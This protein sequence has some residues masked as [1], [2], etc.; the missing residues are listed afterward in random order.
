VNAGTPA[1]TNAAWSE[2]RHLTNPL[3][4]RYSAITWNAHRIHY[5]ADYAREEEGYPAIVQ[6]GGLTMQLLLDAAVRNAPGATLAHF[7]ARLT[8]PIYVGATVTLNGSSLDN[9][10]MN[11]W[12]ADAEGM[13]CG[14]MALEFG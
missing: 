11:A 10:R 5:D 1:P 3:I 6:N 9:G 2:S 4:F 8:R 13:L 7:T 14:E 12:V